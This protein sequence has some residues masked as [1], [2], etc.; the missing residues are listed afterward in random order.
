MSVIPAKSS[1]RPQPPA[2]VVIAVADAE[3]DAL[4]K[5]VIAT[6]IS[7]RV[8]RL[9]TVLFLVAL[10]GV[11]LFQAA[12]ELARGQPVQ[13]LTIFKFRE[14]PSKQALDEFESNMRTSSV[15][16]RCVEPRI[17]ALLSAALGFGNSKVVIG[18]SGWLFYL[19]GI[20][21]VMGPPLLDRGALKSR[22][23]KLSESGEDS[24][25]PDPRPAILRFHRDCVAAG[26]QL[27]VLPIPDKATLQPAQLTARFAA[28]PSI[29]VADNP[30]YDQLLAEL[31]QAGVDIYDAR[32][33][34]V[35]AGD[36]RF[37]RQDTHWTPD[38]MEEVARGVSAHVT[39]TTSLPALAHPFKPTIEAQQIANTGD[40]AAMLKLDASQTVCPQQTVTVHRIS[41]AEHGT[42][43]APETSA[44]IVLLGDSFSNIYSAEAMGW[45]GAAG[46]GAQLS[47]FLERPIDVIARNGS[48]AT[49]TR[50]EFAARPNPFL[51]KRVVIWEFAVRELANQNWIPIP[52]DPP[53]AA[54]GNPGNGKQPTP[55]PA[56][57]L[58]LV[59]ELLTKV[60][61]F[62]VDE[63][64]DVLLTLRFKVREVKS[65]TYTAQEVVVNMYG[66]KN[67]KLLPA[68]TYRLGQACHLTISSEAPPETRTIK[69]LNFAKGTD[70]PLWAVVTG[71]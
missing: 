68:A 69:T 51:G 66:A 30:G 32:P 33:V 46:L 47:R 29:A 71:E 3:Q 27:I 43:W 55:K 65:G 45:G 59:G 44:D 52:V 10:F 24:P 50:Q 11:P 4:R 64:P 15:L 37:L 60:R 67:R 41:D 28:A 12:C 42:A 7:P 56:E 23:R 6:E 58:T 9:M 70:Q 21:Y 19:P 26:V 1:E 38:W 61:S 39:Q 54:P 5:G 14:I 20:E 40:I 13:A 8:A 22:G 2:T 63:Y 18:R 62:D 16:K 53:R 17:Q 25:N 48:G 36:E 35:A 57:Q 34:G 49:V 31:R